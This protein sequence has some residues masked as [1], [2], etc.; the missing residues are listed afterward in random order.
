M[1]QNLFAMVTE[2]PIESNMKHLK[3]NIFMML[4]Q[5]IR[6]KGWTQ[7][8]AAKALKITEPRMSNLVKGRLDKFSIEAL[9]ELVVR[10][11][12]DFDVDV[13]STNKASP[14]S[15]QLKKRKKK[16]APAA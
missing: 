6:Q 10:S 12:Y 5:L 2:D 4:T 11:G 1:T 8:A 14:L 15:F 7:A 3:V 13:D 16:S 9:L